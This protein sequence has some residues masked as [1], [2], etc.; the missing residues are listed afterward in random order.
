[1]I[2]RIIHKLRRTFFP[3]IQDRWRAD[4]GDTKL[5]LEYPL[6]PDSLVM[7]LGGFEGQWAAD[8]YS[9]YG[10]QVVIFEPVASFADEIQNRFQTNS[11]IEVCQYGLGHGCRKEEIHL[12]ADGSSIFANGGQTEMIA[13][14]D[15]VEWFESRGNPKVALAKINIEG[16]EYELLERL[17]QGGIIPYIENLQ[18]QFHPIASDSRDRMSAIQAILSLTHD[19]KW[20]Y[21]FVWES[22]SIKEN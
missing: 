18:I 6:F 15:A 11:S 10:C 14:H 12:S 16:G 22:W 7:D 4:Q 1:V 3:T 9:R 17:A 8:I 13:I 5:R 20:Q 19:L 21:D 2:K